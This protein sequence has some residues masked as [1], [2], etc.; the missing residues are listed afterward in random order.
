M[1]FQ[2]I[3]I[4]ACKSSNYGSYHQNLKIKEIQYSSVLVQKFKKNKNVITRP[5]LRGFR[6]YINDISILKDEG[7]FPVN[8]KGQKTRFSVI[9]LANK[10]R[11]KIGG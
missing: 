11:E 10:V 7:K 6:K 9:T 5:A 3:Y 2:K 1:G 4:F 8:S